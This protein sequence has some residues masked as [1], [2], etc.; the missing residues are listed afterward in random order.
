MEQVIFLNFDN[1]GDFI[2][3]ESPSVH[4]IFKETQPGTWEVLVE[5]SGDTAGLSAYEIWVDGVDSSTVSFTENTLG[6]VIGD[7]YSPVGFLSNTLLQG[8]VNGSF[9]AG[10][11]Q[12]CGEN[13]IE[14]IGK[15]SVYE[16]GS[17]PGATPLVDLDAK[18][19]LGILSTEAGLNEENFRVT[20]A[21]LL[22][23]SGGG[24]VD[25]NQLVPT[26]EVIPFALLP[27]DAN[28]D[29]VVSAGDYASVQA[30]FGNVGEPGLPGDANG[31]GVVSAGDYAAVQA[32]FGNTASGM[33]TI[34]E[35]AT[36]AAFIMGGLV[37]IRKKNRH[38]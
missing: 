32:N 15:E 9:N 23:Y 38:G 12:G 1:G 22:N 10:N 2:G 3:P 37:L 19:L 29:G 30:N 7:N 28:G 11:F 4:Y 31:D 34:P 27:G 17:D 13:A 24:F 16:E 35:P 20:T 36:F 14:G 33:D 8:D 18:A 6:T 26:L 21:G 5:V 25:A